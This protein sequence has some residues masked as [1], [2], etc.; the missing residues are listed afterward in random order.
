MKATEHLAEKVTPFLKKMNN[1]KRN[2][3]II[4]CDNAGKNKTLEEN[5]V[6]HSE[7]I[8]FEFMSPG[9]T[10]KNRLVEQGFATLYFLCKQ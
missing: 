7:E 5:C 9:T 4:I 8:K 10:Q 3:K 2:V 1:T 6:K